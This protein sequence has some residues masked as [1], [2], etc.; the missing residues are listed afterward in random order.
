MA[1]QK[2]WVSLTQMTIFTE[3]TTSIRLRKGLNAAGR[4]TA[5][6]HNF[7]A[8]LCAV[9]LMYETFRPDRN[10]LA[11]Y[12][13]NEVYAAYQQ[14]EWTLTMEMYLPHLRY[15]F[16][17][18][19]WSKTWRSFYRR[20]RRRLLAKCAPSLEKQLVLLDNLTIDYNEAGIGQKILGEMAA[21]ASLAWSPG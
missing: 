18:A 14:E 12:Y 9:L 10:L 16:Y 13:H 4:D 11:I 19:D 21:D 17:P 7:V 8:Y 1:N 20:T 15:T 2:M 5:A 6:F 3:E